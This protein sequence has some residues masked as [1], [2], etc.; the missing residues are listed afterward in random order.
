[1]GNKILLPIFIFLL[2]AASVWASTTTIN[3]SDDARVESAYANQNFGSAT[4]LKVGFDNSPAN[5][6]YSYLKFPTS[7]IPSGATIASAK[8]N[9][10]IVKSESVLS[11]YLWVHL[12]KVLQDW[13][14]GTINWNNK[15]ADDQNNW[16][17][18][19]YDNGPNQPP[20]GYVEWDCTELFRQAYQQSKPLNIMFLGGNGGTTQYRNYLSLQSR[21]ASLKPYVAVD[22]TTPPPNSPPSCSFEPVNNPTINEGQSQTFR[23]I[24]SDPDGDALTYKWFLDGVQV[25]SGSE[26]TY[27]A[28]YDDAGV[29]SVS[30]TVNDGHGHDASHNWVLTVLNVN[31]APTCQGFDPAGN[32][33]M[34]EGDTV[35]FKAVECADPDGDEIYFA[36]TL[37]GQPVGMDW[38]NYS[39]YADF[40]SAGTHLVNVSVTDPYGEGVKHD[41]IATVQNVPTDNF[42]RVYPSPKQ[43]QNGESFN[44]TMEINETQNVGGVQFDLSFDPFK[45]LAYAVAPVDCKGTFLDK[46][47]KPVEGFADYSNSNKKVRFRC[48]RTQTP[49]VN[50]FG[51]LLNVSF[52]AMEEG[53]TQLNFSNVKVFND[54]LQNPKDLGNYENR[55]GLV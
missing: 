52:T 12:R 3:P 37:D 14:E 16:A 24:C 9:I 36:W 15:P 41:W 40:N 5:E 31:R 17:S 38:E 30:V 23:A 46:D 34:N 27:N 55:N 26:Y 20:D 48:L 1:M 39:Y 54:D 51:F 10:A 13:S 53:Q 47:G 33:T 6:M 28:D 45:T 18:K 2:F 42:V 44:L 32:P 4:R 50:G 21:E 22:W 25:G 49:G 35:N 43:V 19:Y 8:C 29:H 11:N 7:G